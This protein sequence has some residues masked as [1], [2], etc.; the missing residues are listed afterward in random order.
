MTSKVVYNGELRTTATHLFSGSS[1]VTDAPLDNHGK[2][3]TFSPTDLVATALA[4]CLMTV[5]GIHIRNNQLQVSSMEAEILKTMG[6]GPRRITQIDV[7]I[8]MVSN[9]SD[10]EKATLERIARACPVAHSLHADIVQNIQ[11]NWK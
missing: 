6:S 11:F 7:Q 4:S 8:Q 5:M 10:E 3:E 9:C 2:A 1:I